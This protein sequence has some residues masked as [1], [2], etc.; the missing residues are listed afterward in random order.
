VFSHGKIVEE[1]KR[2]EEENTHCHELFT[3][4]LFYS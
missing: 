1:T 2:E 3:A 4:A